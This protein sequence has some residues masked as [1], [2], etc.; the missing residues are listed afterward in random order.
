MDLIALLS[1]AAGLFWR[2]KSFWGLALLPASGYFMAALGRLWLLDVGRRDFFPLLAGL[3]DPAAL[4]RILFS[5]EFAAMFSNGRF[6]LFAFFWLFMGLI[7][8][9]LL[10][11]LAEAAVIEAAWGAENGRFPTLRQA[12]TD[13][14]RLLGRFIAIDAIVFL[15]WFFIAL[16]ALLILFVSL[17]SAALLPPGQSATSL[18]LSIL[19]LGSACAGLLAC[20]LVPFSFV[21]LRFRT[22]AFRDAAI[23]QHS[24][25]QSVQHTWQVIRR[26]LGAV[27]LLVAL[28]W[29][30]Q[31]LFNLLMAGVSLP[32][33][34]LPTLLHL[35]D[36][37]VVGYALG[38][39]TAVLLAL[40][41]SILF[42]YLAIVWTLGY[43]EITR[44][45]EPG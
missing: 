15:P 14:A 2:R 11:T 26:H 19:G 5:P 43:A 42:V 36:W 18:F 8:F 39:I 27:L 4:E 40:P 44:N 24:T 21:T 33:S 35:G 45:D 13:G 31:Y 25:G 16:A 20:L 1:R 6:L 22:L 3:D 28:L 30:L 38:V 12:L 41:Q 17:V 9:W 7:G 10:Y 37:P 23:F 32:L 29:G 34:L